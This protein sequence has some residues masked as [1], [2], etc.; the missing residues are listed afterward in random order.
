MGCVIKRCS[1]HRVDIA[2]IMPSSSV[3]QSVEPPHGSRVINEPAGWKCVFNINQHPPK[4]P[5]EFI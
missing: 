1:D 2:P 5:Y 4:R 3:H